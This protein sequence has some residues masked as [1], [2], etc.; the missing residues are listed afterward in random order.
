M[1]SPDRTEGSSRVEKQIQRLEF[2]ARNPRDAAM[3]HL[4]RY[5]EIPHFNVGG[6]AR[7][8]LAPHMI[9]KLY[10]SGRTAVRE[11]EEFIR[12]KGL[13]KCHAAQELG[14]RLIPSP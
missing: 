14:E 12:G 9:A 8:R 6:E 11:L 13:E 3:E 10:K 5:E 7:V 2:E 1:A 4:K